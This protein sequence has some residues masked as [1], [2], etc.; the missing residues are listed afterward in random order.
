MPCAVM[1]LPSYFNSI[2]VRLELILQEIRVLPKLNFNSIKVR[3][4]L[5]YLRVTGINERFQ[6]HKGAIRTWKEILIAILILLFQF[7]KGAIR[8]FV[9]ASVVPMPTNFNSIKVRL[10]L[11]Y[12]RVTGINERFQ[13]HK[14]AIRTWKE[15]LIAI[16]IL[17]FQFHK[18]A[19]RT[20]V[21]ASVV[22]MPTNF[23]SIKVRLELPPR[24]VAA[25]KAR[26]SIP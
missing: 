25:P 11:R 14:G 13:F 4:E 1:V 3:L 8:T 16:L 7:H 26:I 12:L 20:F 23:N 24:T 6:F 10:E 15:I 17:L 21:F 22:P 19:I 5:R 18:G 2:K 9:F